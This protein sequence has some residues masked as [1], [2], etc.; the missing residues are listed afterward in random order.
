MSA[1]G[2]DG[3]DLVHAVHRL[4]DDFYRSDARLT[5]DDL[6]LMGEQAAA[7]FRALHPEV[8]EDAVQ[9]LKWCYTY[10]FK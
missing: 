4:E 8:G 2:K 10:D 5:A 6:V 3:V 7:E 9:A 1:F